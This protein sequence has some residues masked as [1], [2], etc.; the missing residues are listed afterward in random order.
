MRHHATATIFFAGLCLG[1]GCP[2]L[3]PVNEPEPARS[4][5]PSGIYSGTISWSVTY[6]YTDEENLPEP[7]ET[8]EAV[9]F[10][11]FGMPRS[12]AGDP[13]DVGYTSE[14]VFG[15]GTLRETL[16]AVV[17]SSNGVVVSSDVTMTYS[18]GAGIL[19]GPAQRSYRLLVD[20]SVQVSI[21]VS[22]SGQYSGYPYFENHVGT[23]IL[24][25]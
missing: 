20:G 15:N 2:G 19:R 8:S 25:R 12:P 1:Q 7:R 16:K 3:A 10:D 14:T 13:L 21:T 11:E 18:D 5:I 4:S 24:F 9:L 23:G 6:G 17:A 22:T